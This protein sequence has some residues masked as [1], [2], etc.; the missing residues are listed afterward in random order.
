[1]KRVS[2]AALALVALTAA[3]AL[4]TSADPTTTAK[5]STVT[6]LGAMPQS[7]LQASWNRWRDG[8]AGTFE[9]SGRNLPG[10]TS[11]A[12]GTWTSPPFVINGAQFFAT[13]DRTVQRTSASGAAAA[14]T[15]RLRHRTVGGAWSRWL[16]LGAGDTSDGV[17]MARPARQQGWDIFYVRGVRGTQQIEVDTT[18]RVSDASDND[19]YTTVVI[20]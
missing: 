14:N 3:P 20:P 17:L 19:L 12:D 8:H 15:V 7:T 2:T 13:I 9:V 10:A 18:Y 5:V 11:S 4:A 1:V 6:A 16:T